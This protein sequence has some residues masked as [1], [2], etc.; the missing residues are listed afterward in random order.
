GLHL[1]HAGGGVLAVPDEFEVSYPDTGADEMMTVEESSFWFSHRN[2]VIAMALERFAPAGT[3]WDIG[4]AHRVSGPQPHRHPPAWVAPGMAACLHAA[5]RGVKTVV[6]ATL[7]SLNLAADSLGGASMFDVV[8][9]L[10]DPVAV[11]SEVC[12]VLRP[13][14]HVY[15]TVPAYQALWSEEDVH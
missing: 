15:I 1:Q 4:G 5:E 10:P 2:A 14:G 13:D 9:H 7:E 12:R 3:V 8:E 11:L 6:R